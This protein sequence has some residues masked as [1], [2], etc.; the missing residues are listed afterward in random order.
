MNNWKQARI[1]FLA[2]IFTA[3]TLV[4]VKII[5]MTAFSDNQ[6]NSSKLDILYQK[7]ALYK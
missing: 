4:V 1:P 6:K 2:F 3:I 5:L 7:I